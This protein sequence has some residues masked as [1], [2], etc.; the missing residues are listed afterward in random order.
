MKRAALVLIVIGAVLFLGYRMMFPA[1]QWHQ[2]L[3]MTIATPS[4]EVSGASVTEVRAGEKPTLL[5][6]ESPIYVDKRGEVVVLEVT[7]GRYLFVLLDGMGSWAE[8]A[9]DR[10][11]PGSTFAGSMAFVEDQKGGPP[12]P[13]PKEALPLTVTFD[14]IADPTSVRRV[15]PEGFAATFGPGVSLT[16]VT[17]EITGERV[18]EGR[19]QPLL[20]CLTIPKACI[21]LNESLPYG[22]PMRNLLNSHFWR[23]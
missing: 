9:Y 7:P 6:E 13:L 23:K 10:N 5:H 18:T 14:D 19:V 17:P 12:V 15:D 11:R 2:K 8:A 1:F 21:P 16:A 4:G 22:H 20:P 3:T